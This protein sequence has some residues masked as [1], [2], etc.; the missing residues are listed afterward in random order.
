MSRRMM[1]ITYGLFIGTIIVMY[2]SYKLETYLEQKPKFNGICLFDVDDTLTTGTENEKV[3][4]ICLKAGYAVG[5]STANSLYTPYT[6]QFFQW[7]PKNLYDFM[8]QHNFDTFN[9]VS[10]L[11]LNGKINKSA[12]DKVDTNFPVK[13]PTLYGWRKGFSLVSTAN[14]YGITDMS[15]M[16]LFDDNRN[17]IEGI[18]AFTDNKAMVICSGHDCGGKLDSNSVYFLIQN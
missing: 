5:I 12:Y 15:K 18:K 16:I 3:V 7:M 6:I 17:Y 9:N 1:Y 4:D 8:V 2:A 10:S 14:L 11:Y 13:S